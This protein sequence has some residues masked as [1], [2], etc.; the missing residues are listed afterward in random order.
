MT[1]LGFILI[2]FSIP[3]P[4]KTSV[5]AADECY[6]EWLGG[7]LPPIDKCSLLFNDTSEV[8]LKNLV[9]RPE[10]LNKNAR[11]GIAINQQVDEEWDSIQKVNGG[12][13]FV[14]FNSNKTLCRPVNVTVMMYFYNGRRWKQPKVILD[15]N[16]TTCLNRILSDLER[17]KIE[18]KCPNVTWP[19][20]E[21]PLSGT[22][23]TATPP[24]PVK[25]GT[26]SPTTTICFLILGTTLLVCAAA[27]AIALVLQRRKRQERNEEGKSSSE[28]NW[29]VDRANVTIGT[30][31]GSGCF[32]T[33]YK[34]TLKDS[35]Q[36]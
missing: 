7:S 4:L 27:V 17:E 12:T 33:V 14:T 3:A 26:I 29:E 34:G 6:V 9:D 32:G 20:K 11:I 21:V 30:E 8:R 19:K 13:A 2:F 15:L 24:R 22:L 31:L 28:D 10:C 1:G 23:P 18:T 25:R 16:P 35:R 36:V 5:L